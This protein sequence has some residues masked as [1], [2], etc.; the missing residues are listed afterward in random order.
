MVKQKII[1]ENKSYTFAD[2]FKLNHPTEKVVEYFG[3]QHQ[4]D[5]LVLESVCKPLDRL[6]YLKDCLNK[7]I[8]HVNLTSEAARREFLIAPILSELIYCTS[9][10]ITVEYSLYVNDHL[11][12]ILD[13][14]LESENNMLIIEAKS[15]DLQRGFTQLAVQLIAPDRCT[16]SPEDKLYGAVSIGDLWQFGILCRQSKQ[17]VQDIMF[18]QIPADVEKLLHILMGILEKA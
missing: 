10:K 14:Y 11:H 7:N 1:D 12:G 18:Y 5:E 15:A 3:Y 13:Y 9:A 16:D 6:A 4:R 2:Y 17:I 8:R